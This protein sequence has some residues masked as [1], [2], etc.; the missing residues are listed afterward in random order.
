MFP[1]TWDEL[2]RPLRIA[3]PMV[4]YSKLPFRLVC[5]RWGTQIAY[6]PMIMSDSFVL[7][8]RGRDNEFTTCSGDKPL[9]IQFGANDSDL[10]GTAAA[11]ASK[12]AD[13][14]D[15][16]CGCPQK[17]A[18][19]EGYGSALLC[20]PEKISD[21]IRVAR[22]RSTVPVAVKIRINDDLRR[23]VDLVRAVEA[24]GAAWITVHG[25]TPAQRYKTRVNLEAIKLVK[26][27]VQVPVVANGDVLT[28]RD[29]MDIAEATGVDGVMAARG[30]LSNPA[31]FGD[32]TVPP[33]ECLRDLLHTLADYH[34]TFGL[35]HQHMVYA[36]GPLLSVADRKA[37]GQIFSVAGLVDFLEARC[38]MNDASSHS[39]AEILSPMQAISLTT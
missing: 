28:P 12:I 27:T 4:R 23:T 20:D 33:I 25:R 37:L 10:F 38:P 31:L 22:N 14:V 16:N 3:A 6:T 17:W 34:L 8:K 36:L 24:A 19:D 7:S 9:V 21:M 5:R 18:M 39:L 30:L 15:L 11:I 1:E 29:T 13:A 32:Y 35:V 2:Q 26:S